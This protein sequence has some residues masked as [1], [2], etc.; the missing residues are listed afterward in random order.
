MAFANDGEGQVQAF[1]RWSVPSGPVLCAVWLALWRKQV[2]R[3]HRVTVQ[4]EANML[5]IIMNEQKRIKPFKM[6]Q[7]QLK[8][9]SMVETCT[10]FDADEKRPSALNRRPNLAAARTRPLGMN[11]QTLAPVGN[12]YSRLEKICGAFHRQ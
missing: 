2:W 1:V 3:V 10:A 8:R 6:S 5:G 12:F 4:D 11:I 7:L 9:R